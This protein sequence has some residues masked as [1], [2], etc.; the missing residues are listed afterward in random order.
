MIFCALMMPLHSIS[1]GMALPA[2][3]AT[4]QDV[5]PAKLKGLSWGAAMLALYILGGAW[6]PLLVGAVSDRFNGG[7]IGLAL[8]IGLAGLF[9]FVASALWFLTAR[10]VEAD[11]QNAR[12]AS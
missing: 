10:H 6:G 12:L 8:G 1:V 7:Y 4:T 5:V 2:V 9:G 11:R 3:A